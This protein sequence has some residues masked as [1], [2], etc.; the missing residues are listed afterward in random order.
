MPER[1]IFAVF[2]SQYL[3]RHSLVKAISVGR[4]LG[5]SFSTSTI[6]TSGGRVKDILKMDVFMRFYLQF[7]QC[8]TIVRKPVQ[9]F[10]PIGSSFTTSFIS[11]IGGRVKFISKM[12][13]FM[14]VS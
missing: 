12:D 5:K 11:I 7:P 1:D 4:K 14:L 2:Y 3:I 13:V 9:V 8:F 6:S 10:V